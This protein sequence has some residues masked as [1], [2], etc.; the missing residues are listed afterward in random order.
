LV[1][2]FAKAKLV[3]ESAERRMASSYSMIQGGIGGCVYSDGK[4][5]AI[6]GFPG[7]P[8]DE[9]YKKS[10]REKFEKCGGRKEPWKQMWMKALGITAEELFDLSAKPKVDDHL[11]CIDANTGK[12]LWKRSYEQVANN[13]SGRGLTGPAVLI[14]PKPKDGPHNLPCVAYGKV[15]AIGYGGTLY[16]LDAQTGK[17]VW[18][19]VVLPAVQQSGK[20]ADCQT[21]GSVL[22]GSGNFICVA[23]PLNAK[24]SPVLE[25]AAFDAATGEKRWSWK[26]GYAATGRQGAVRYTVAGKD[27]IQWGGV[28]LDAATGKELWRVPGAG[29]GAGSPCVGD[30]YLVLGG[31]GAKGPGLTGYKLDA[32]PTKVP[33]KV[34]ELDKKHASTHNCTP[35]ICRGHV[36]TKMQT[37]MPA[38]GDIM[39]VCVALATGDFKGKVGSHTDSHSSMFG[40]DGVVLYE[41]HAF[42]ADPANFARLAN[43]GSLMKQEDTY[44]SSH[45]GCY[46]AGRL[47]LKGLNSIRCYDLREKP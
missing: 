22:Y 35:I 34:W 3:W 30:G 44:A 17:E 5:Y 2:D 37:D 40:G 8:V 41:A 23:A 25:L 14:C 16:C 21:M 46:V 29:G 42:R 45:T 43:D 39:Y 19:Q 31:D 38:G 33:T 32:D 11:I 26:P 10:Q 1:D 36:Y 15:A 28:C 13:T 18:K 12:T 47:Y 27:L 6:W 9:E 4:A 24:G 20:M 7:G